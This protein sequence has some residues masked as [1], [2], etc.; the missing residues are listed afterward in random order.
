MNAKIKPPMEWP[1]TGVVTV[2]YEDEVQDV[3]ASRYGSLT[4]LAKEGVAKF[5]DR[6][7]WFFPDFDIRWTY[8]EFDAVVNNNEQ[9]IH[10]FR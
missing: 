5:G 3:W 8:N 10:G 2:R 4:E 7:M 1:K 6:E 9:F